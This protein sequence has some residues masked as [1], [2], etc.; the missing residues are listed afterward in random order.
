MRALAPRSILDFGCGEA[1]TLDE[2]ARLGVD[3]ENYEGVDL[4]A[5]AL[6]AARTRWPRLRFSH[7][8]IFD[9]DFDGRRYGVTL[10]LEVMEHLFE[11][12]RM[13]K[14]L[15]ELTDDAIILSVPHEPW[16]QLTNLLRGRDF[17]R[18]G[19]HPEHVQHWNPRTFAD[20]ISPHAEVVRI[21]ASFPFIIATARPWR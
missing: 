21:R 8:D 4:R 9:P 14:R 13:L 5:D 2:L 10:A 1:F 3:V 17:I 7:A 18:L 20:F 6:A 15:A 12:D 16:F 19:N 11:P